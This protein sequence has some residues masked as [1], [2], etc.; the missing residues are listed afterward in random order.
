MSDEVKIE[1]VS[2]KLVAEIEYP[3]KEEDCKRIVAYR[4]R[5]DSICIAVVQRG[6]TMENTHGIVPFN[7]IEQAQEFAEA[8]LEM[9]YGVEVVK[10]LRAKIF[11]R[12]FDIRNRHK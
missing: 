8:L 10:D 9:I 6:E 5:N 7:Q 12:A 11:D 4:N 3:K 2:H 1:K